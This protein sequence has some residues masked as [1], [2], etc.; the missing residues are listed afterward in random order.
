MTDRL[1]L[2]DAD[3]RSFE[4]VVVAV[5]GDR[6]ELD[7]TAFYATSMTPGTWCG[8]PG[9]PPSWTSVPS[10][11]G[12]STRWQARYPRSLRRSQARWTTPDGAR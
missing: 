4:A 9:P 11:D 8:P 1:Y 3:L 7:R 2:R 12:C 6:V 5:D 10:T